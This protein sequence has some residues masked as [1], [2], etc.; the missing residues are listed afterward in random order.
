MLG[1]SVRG[2]V[3]YNSLVLAKIRSGFPFLHLLSLHSP[4][5]SIKI[6]SGFHS[7]LPV[8]I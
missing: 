6:D 3:V 7:T 5:G 1:S 2:K 8:S 4:R